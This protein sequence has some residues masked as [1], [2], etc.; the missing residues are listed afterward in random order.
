MSNETSNTSSIGAAWPPATASN[1][2]MRGF[3]PEAVASVQAADELID[4]FIEAQKTAEA[5]PTTTRMNMRVVV[6]NR[7]IPYLS[8]VLSLEGALPIASTPDRSVVYIAWNDVNRQPTADELT[9]H[10]DLIQKAQSREVSTASPYLEL[11]HKGYTPR[12][13][14][15]HM[16]ETE[17]RGY[18]DR[19]LEL[20]GKFGFDETGV[21]E[22]LTSPNNTIAYIAGE[23]ETII[24][25]VMAERG[26]IPVLGQPNNTLTVIEITEAITDPGVRGK[27]LYRALS[28]FLVQH[29][30]DHHMVGEAP[31]DVVYGESNLSSPGVVVAAHR[32]GR[33]FATDDASHLGVI[34]QPGFGILQQNVKVNDGVETRPYNDFVLTYQPIPTP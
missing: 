25:T 23:N 10:L 3:Y 21:E 24:S 32:N 27:G 33:R 5:H 12:I 26:T 9:A 2:R 34:D 16:S 4:Q 18:R 30:V 8:H 1:E 17:R 13:I 11:V 22:L 7:I 19:F 29:I 15:D 14:D 31:V 28:G 6:E 20:Y